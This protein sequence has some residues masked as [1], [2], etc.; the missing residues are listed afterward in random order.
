MAGLSFFSSLLPT[1]A[2]LSG[3]D[4]EMGYTQDVNMEP[5]GE[6]LYSFGGFVMILKFFP[7]KLLFPRGSN[8]RI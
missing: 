8:D 2:Q 7:F 5:P 1:Q 3:V 6:F 4:Y